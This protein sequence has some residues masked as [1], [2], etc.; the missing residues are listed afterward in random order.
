MI[1]GLSKVA[2]IALMAGAITL[3]MANPARAQGASKTAAPPPELQ[4]CFKCHGPGGVSQIPTHPSIAGQSA[5]YIVKQMWAFRRSYQAITKAAQDA[6]A[7]VENG[8]NNRPAPVRA[9]LSDR[10]DPIMGHIGASMNET[11]F[12]KLA[13]AISRLPC[14]GKAEPDPV[15]PNEK[16][17]VRP[18]AVKPCVG[19]H[20]KNG[21][22]NMPTVPNLAGQQ[23][24]YLRRE[25]LLLR[26]SAWN[27][28]SAATGDWRSHPIMEKQASRLR[29]E[30]VDSIASY[31]AQLSCRG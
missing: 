6:K 19:C 15:D 28:K 9:V 24:A 16:R 25:L 26:A 20:G 29:I 21:I 7:G 22:A 27:D 8:Q 30:D 2:A 4:L 1:A 3:G 13:K 5:N 31:Y 11:K 14:D 18:D 23:R 10:S 12:S 17:P